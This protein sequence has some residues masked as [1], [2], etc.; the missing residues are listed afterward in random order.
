MAEIPAS[1]D[2][3]GTSLAVLVPCRDEGLAIR[4]VVTRFRAALPSA[5][6]YVY[7][8][9][10]TDDTF[11][12]ALDAGA[13][14]RREQR[15]GKGNVVRRMFSDIEAD[16][17]I[18]VDGDDTYDPGVAPALIAELLSGPFDLVNAARRPVS[19]DAH[20]EGHE[21]GNRALN[22]LVRTIFGA[23]ATD[24]LSGYKVMSRRFVK[25]F[26]A[27]ST[28][29]E[30]ETEL[31][32]HALEL[33]MPVSEV[34]ADYKKRK[35]GS[36]SKLSTFRDGWRVIRLIVTLVKEERPLQFFTL[37]AYALAVCAL[38][39]GIPVIVEFFKTGLV[40][41]LPTAVLAST[42]GLTAIISLFSGLILDTVTRGRREMKRLHY[43][44]I[45]A[46]AGVGSPTGRGSISRTAPVKPASTAQ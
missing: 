45:A 27:L 42:F 46:P 23:V 15:P 26:P 9:C 24:M 16:V 33:M 19:A 28:G 39:L 20:R 5:N 6:I 8:N 25:S 38:G 35:E 2:L 10:S 41:R 7:D 4:D 17:Y 34:A 37:I 32:V 31:M 22:F 3:S 21:F 12:K 11:A 40:P 43:L 36:F 1:P 44:A 13:I 30:I 18:L 14:V 29:F